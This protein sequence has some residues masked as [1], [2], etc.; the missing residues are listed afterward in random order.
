[1]NIKRPLL[2]IISSL[3][4]FLLI[5]F[6]CS[7]RGSLFKDDNSVSSISDS[8]GIG[9]LREITPG[10]ERDDTAGGSLPSGST[11]DIS[12][13]DS[14]KGSSIT[15]RG[16]E[17]S[18]VHGKKYNAGS[19]KPSADRDTIPVKKEITTEKLRVP[20]TETAARKDD[21]AVRNYKSGDERITA[22]KEEIKDNAD[23]DVSIAK[24]KD[25]VED[26]GENKSTTEKKK[27]IAE[28]TESAEKSISG[29]DVKDSMIS[30]SDRKSETGDGKIESEIADEKKEVA[31]VISDKSGSS[32]VKYSRLDR[33]YLYSGEVLTGT[34]TA[35]GDEYTVIT[36]DGI[37]K[38]AVRDIQSNDILK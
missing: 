33:I 36:P 35:R 4:L 32:K 19:V 14:Q 29:K 6:I 15:S 9:Y 31:K 28:E 10:E 1:M 11:V 7:E 3:L 38:I 21:G 12:A 8:D 17:T 20:D 13:D 5:F 30:A 27:I 26:A 22:G 23:K 37:R 34:V 16:S 25:T 18:G 2:I 24:R